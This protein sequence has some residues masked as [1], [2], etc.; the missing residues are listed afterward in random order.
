MRLYGKKRLA[1]AKSLAGIRIHQCE[2]TH[3]RSRVFQPFP[4]TIRQPQN[5]TS[6]FRSSTEQHTTRTFLVFFSGEGMHRT[7]HALI[8]TLPKP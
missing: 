5:S 4:F 7:V 1:W 8:F 6:E 3:T 2:P